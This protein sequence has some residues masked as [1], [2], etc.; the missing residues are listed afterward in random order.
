M[1]DAQFVESRRLSVE[2]VGRIMDVEP[3]LLGE[4]ERNDDRQQALEVF[5]RVQLIPR[6]RRIERG[7]A[8]DPDLFPVSDGLYPRF[9]LTDDSFITAVDRSRIQHEQIQDGRRLV[10]E[11]RAE[12]GMGPLPPVPDDWTQA[13]GMIPQITPVGGAPNPTSDESL[14]AADLQ[15]MIGDLDRQIAAERARLQI[16]AR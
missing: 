10:D 12:E 2:D 9:E 7:I 13:P 11:I 6:L 5:L 16:G 1:T 4:V 3:V 14:V 8:A 15:R